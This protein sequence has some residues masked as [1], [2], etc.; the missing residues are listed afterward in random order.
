MSFEGFQK[1]SEPR[2][3]AEEKALLERVQA[4]VPQP[5]VNSEDVSVVGVDENKHPQPTPEAQADFF[6][7]GKN[8]NKFDT[9][10]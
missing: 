7:K 3:T 5:N 10:L 4:Q 6:D 2:L 1:A 8:P 9:K